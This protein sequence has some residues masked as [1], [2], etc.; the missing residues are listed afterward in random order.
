[1]LVHAANGSWLFDDDGNG[2]LDPRLE[3]RGSQ[4]LNGRLNVWLG[5]YDNTACSATL[6]VQ[7]FYE[8]PVAP[9]PACRLPGLE[10]PG[11]AD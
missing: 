5:T 11:R 8:Q 6:Q 4:L 3:I 2:N 10:F 9:T 1:M 7:A